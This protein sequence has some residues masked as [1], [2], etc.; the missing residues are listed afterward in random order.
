MECTKTGTFAFIIGGGEKKVFLY[1]GHTFRFFVR[2]CLPPHSFGMEEV[3]EESFG[4]PCVTCPDACLGRQVRRGNE[5]VAPA[6]RV[7]PNR[8]F[9]QRRLT[10]PE[11]FLLLYVCHDYKQPLINGH[12]SAWRTPKDFTALSPFQT[13]M[14]PAQCQCGHEADHFHLD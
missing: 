3:E 7:A 11:L 1:M 5:S 2:P 12:P 10:P 9:N 4:C 8:S 6:G 14:R 13:S